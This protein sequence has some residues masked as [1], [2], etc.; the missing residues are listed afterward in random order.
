MD[1]LG[2]DGG[3]LAG[4]FGAGCA[5]AYGFL[6]KVLVGPLKKQMEE[7]KDDCEARD[8]RQED[9]IMWLQSLLL[10]HGTGAMR[11]EIQKVVS[12]QNLEI[13]ALKEEK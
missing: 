2:H 5:A 7:L 13:R 3:A 1:F 6:Q 12:E 10:T 11:Q 8:R 4:A 9:R